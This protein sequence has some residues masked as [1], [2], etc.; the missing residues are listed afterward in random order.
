VELDA[1]YGRAYAA[2]AWGY[3]ALNLRGWAHLIKLSNADAYKKTLQYLNQ[4]SKNPT[5]LYYQING[6]IY[7]FVGN[8]ETALKQYHHA[9]AVDPGDSLTYAH[10][11]NNL[12]LSGRAKEAL[13]Y[14]RTAM[15]LDPHYPGIYVEVLGYAQFCLERYSEAASAFEEALKLNPDEERVYPFL[16]AAYAYLGRSRDAQTAVARFTEIKIARGGM[17]PDILDLPIG[18]ADLEYR[19]RAFKGFLL[20]G[21]KLNAL[22]RQYAAKYQLHADEIYAL[23][24]GHKVHGRNLAEATERSVTVF[25]KGAVSMSGDWG[26]VSAGTFLLEGDLLCVLAMEGTRFCGNVFR[27]P[28]GTKAKENEYIW[29]D[30]TFSRTE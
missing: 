29:R 13:Q 19:T 16:A 7:D 17:P 8:F 30:G 26:K 2:L 15:R 22:D 1:N 18:F 10:I 27:I 25:S 20:A 11:A 6:Q 14:V 21:M 28:G 5:V 23:F 9:I 24:V 3:H 4:A 12:I